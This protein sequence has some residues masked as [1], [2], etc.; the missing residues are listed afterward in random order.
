MSA[1]RTANY[2]AGFE[3]R[4]STG[5]LKSWICHDV[6]LDWKEP[7]GL[8]GAQAAAGV[9]NITDAGLTVDTANPNSVGGPASPDWGRAFF[10][11]FNKRFGEDRRIGRPIS[12]D[13][14]AMR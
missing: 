13:G 8:E 5:R 11:T 2:R 12:A 1:I 14:R 10:L 9:F 6:V 4:S 3:N 7:L